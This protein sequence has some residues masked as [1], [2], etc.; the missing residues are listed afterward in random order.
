MPQ[1]RTTRPTKLM[2]RGEH[3]DNA[4]TV[5]ALTSP[6]SQ[7]DNAKRHCADSA[8]T[9]ATGF[10]TSGANKQG[11]PIRNQQALLCWLTAVNAIFH[12]HSKPTIGRQQMYEVNTKHP[13]RT[14]LWLPTHL[15][16]EGNYALDVIASALC[17]YGDFSLAKA[18]QQPVGTLCPASIWLETASIGRFCF[19]APKKNAMRWA[20][21]PCIELCR[22]CAPL[23]GARRTA[24][25]VGGRTR[26]TMA[27]ASPRAGNPEIIAQ[28]SGALLIETMT[29]LSHGGQPSHSDHFIVGGSTCFDVFPA[30]FTIVSCHSPSSFNAVSLSKSDV[31]LCDRQQHAARQD[32]AMNVGIDDPAAP[33]RPTFNHVNSSTANH[34]R[35]RRP[36]STLRGS[37]SAVQ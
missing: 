28:R 29:S 19:Y 36:Y 3:A 33:I 11:R 22:L 32:T 6:P 23:S 30:F 8:P 7:L 17:V 9:G 15:Q 1:S 2:Q 34:S 5:S 13:C 18:A 27:A 35:R 31:L 14:I 16:P 21:V 25:G 10:D 26:G 24:S 4:K 20:R 37:A 12:L